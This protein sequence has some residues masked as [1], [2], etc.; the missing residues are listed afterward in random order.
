[1]VTTKDYECTLSSSAYQK[2]ENH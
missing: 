2:K 1:M